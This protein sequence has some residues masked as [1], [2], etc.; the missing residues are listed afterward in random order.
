MERHLKEEGLINT[1]SFAAALCFATGTTEEGDRVVGLRNNASRQLYP[2][3]VARI[4]PKVSDQLAAQTMQFAWAAVHCLLPTIADIGGSLQSSMIST[5]SI[6]VAIIGSNDYAQMAARALAALKCQVHVITTKSLKFSERN[7]SVTSPSENEMGF[8]A[9]LG[10]FDALLDTLGDE[11]PSSMASFSEETVIDLLK[12]RHNCQQYVS[13]VTR[14]QQL[15]SE[16]GMLSGPGRAKAHVEKLA[17]AQLPQPPAP[18]QL[19]TTIQSLFEAGFTWPANKTPTSTVQQDD[20]TA[21]VRGWTMGDYWES[22]TWPRDIESNARFGFP[23]TSF[24]LWMEETEDEEEEGLMVVRNTSPLLNMLREQKNSPIRDKTPR[25]KKP[26]SEAAA[27]AKER[28][29][30]NPHNI[31]QFQGVR[32]LQDYIV[33]GELTGCVFLSAPFCRTCRYLRPQ[34]QRLSRL[35]KGKRDIVFCQADAT[36]EI[37]KELGRYLGVDAVPSFILFRKGQ[38]YGFPLAV[39]KFPSPVLDRALQSLESGKDWDSKTIRGNQEE[40]SEQ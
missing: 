24:S 35:Q 19:G 25:S 38:I 39:T 7:I 29:E 11:S 3:S 16:A 27:A 17:G 28:Q 36:G 15:F 14:Q 8:A 18:K 33:D 30:Q 4:P 6:T 26:V 20:F 32:G 12:S 13:T 23:T 37:G 1:Q 9:K 10:K 22:S 5:E 2:S 31:L 21:T 40:E 34:Y